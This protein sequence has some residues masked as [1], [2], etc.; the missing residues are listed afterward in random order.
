MKIKKIMK[1]SLI[2]KGKRV[3]G[4]FRLQMNHHIIII[5]IETLLLLFFVFNDEQLEQEA[6]NY[7]QDP[8]PV[9]DI[10]P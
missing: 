5:I 2:H 7:E 1:K 6:D 3:G 9:S 4:V 8:E 10:L